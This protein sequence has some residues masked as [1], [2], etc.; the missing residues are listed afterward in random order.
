MVSISDNYHRQCRRQCDGDDSHSCQHQHCQAHNAHISTAPHHGCQCRIC[1][2][3]RSGGEGDGDIPATPEQ[4]QAIRAAKAIT[5]APLS[6]PIYDLA[7]SPAPPSAQ[8]TIW[9]Q[10]LEDIAITIPSPYPDSCHCHE[11]DCLICH[12]KLAPYGSWQCGHSCCSDDGAVFCQS[13]WWMPDA[14]HINRC[15]ICAVAMAAETLGRAVSEQ[16]LPAR[17]MAQQAEIDTIQQHLWHASHYH[18]HPRD[19]TLDWLLRPSQPS[20]LEAEILHKLNFSAKIEAHISSLN[21]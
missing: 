15:L 9:W 19:I 4:Q 14:H 7:T 16:E 6:Q 2:H 18:P 21:R 5:A 1:Q 17:L 3:I 12:I 20:G 8:P 10:L 13:R 11:D